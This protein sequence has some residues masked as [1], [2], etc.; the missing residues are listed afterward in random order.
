MTLIV[1]GI[2]VTISNMVLSK[3]PNRVICVIAVLGLSATVFISSFMNTFVG[4]VIFY[5]L[6]YGFFIGIGYYPPVKNAY[7][8]LPTRKGLC[9]G[10]C[11]SGF[12][13]GSAIFNT[14]IME[15]VNPNNINLD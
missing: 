2:G 1:V 14:V 11:M 9:S 15:F 10:L 7:L 6:I 3:L 4:Y 13:F 8:H 5:G 12:G